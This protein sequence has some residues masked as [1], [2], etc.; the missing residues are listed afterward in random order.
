MTNEFSNQ[1]SIFVI[2]NKR[3]TRIFTAELDFLK[4]RKCCDK[5]LLRFKF[6]LR[7]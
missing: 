2:L 4:I 6:F 1:N 3:E 5:L 7:A